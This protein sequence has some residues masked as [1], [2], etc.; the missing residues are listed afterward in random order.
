L[1][2]SSIQPIIQGPT[3]NLLY[4]KATST[5][6]FFIIYK[7]K[8]WMLVKKKYYLLFSIAYLMKIIYQSIIIWNCDHS[9][10]SPFIIT[11]GTLVPTILWGLF[12]TPITYRFHMEPWTLFYFIQLIISY[13]HNL[14]NLFHLKLCDST[15]KC[16]FVFIVHILSFS[17]GWHLVEV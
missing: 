15:V 3:C 7:A 10:S 11:V 12:V 4:S 9:H 5:Y 17:C 2:L 16:K 8:G 13:P 6:P 1:N 14:S